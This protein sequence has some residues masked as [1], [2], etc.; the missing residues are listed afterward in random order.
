MELSSSTGRLHA[1]W[2][3]ALQTKA[4]QRNGINQVDLIAVLPSVR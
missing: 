3:Q 4:F 1:V 2:K